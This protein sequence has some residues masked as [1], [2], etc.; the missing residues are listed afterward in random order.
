[1]HLR[2]NTSIGYGFASSALKNR[3]EELTK[4][5]SNNTTEIITQN[6]NSLGD[7]MKQYYKCYKGKKV[8][9]GSIN[10]SSNENISK[11]AN[12]YQAVIDSMNINTDVTPKTRDPLS[13]VT[14]L[15][16]AYRSKRS[17]SK[18]VYTQ[19]MA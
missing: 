13:I 5:L 7:N 4:K 11:S 6:M 2:P 1:M 10:F 9:K 3:I 8:P 12:K 18:L 15:S 19:E 16:N 14:E 17:N